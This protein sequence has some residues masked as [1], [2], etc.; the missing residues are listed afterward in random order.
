MEKQLEKI[1]VPMNLW[2][3]VATFAKVEVLAILAAITWETRW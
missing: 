2:R 1:L 3:L